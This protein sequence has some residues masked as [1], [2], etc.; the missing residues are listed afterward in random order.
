MQLLPGKAVAA[1]WE[2]AVEGWVSEEAPAA[3]LAEALAA[4]SVEGPAEVE[5]PAAGSEEAPVAASRAEAAGVAG[6]PAAGVAIAPRQIE[7]GATL[8]S[9]IR[10]QASMLIPIP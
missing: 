3:G 9:S 2:C 5:G 8:R 10:T 1:G 6:E 7:S 4:P